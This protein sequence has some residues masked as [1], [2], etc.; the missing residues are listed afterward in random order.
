MTSPAQTTRSLARDADFPFP[1][2]KVWK[3]LT[4]S[5][6]LTMWFF[7]ND[8][9][10]VAGHKFTIWSRPIERWDGDFQCQVLSVQAPTTISFAWKGGA[11]ELKGFGKLMNT[12]V[13]WTL[14]ATDDG[15]TH[16]HFEHG[17]FAI[18][19]AYDNVFEII[20][21]GTES[22][23]RALAKRLPDMDEE[24]GLG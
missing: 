2:E 4:D 3:A 6:M 12:K 24:G 15:G 14:S 22:V 9:A 1:V 10:P 5:E 19:E 21:K 16:F 11:E 23:L 17:G 18:D 7:P 13:T 20:T 8:I